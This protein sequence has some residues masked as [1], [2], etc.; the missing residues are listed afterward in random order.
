VIGLGDGML[1]RAD[2]GFLDEPPPTS[3]GRRLWWLSTPPASR[4][5]YPC[6]LVDKALLH[7]RP[8]RRPCAQGLVPHTDQSRPAGSLGAEHGEPVHHL[9]GHSAHGRRQL[10]AVM[11]GTCRVCELVGRR[12]AGDVGPLITGFEV[13]NWF[14]VFRLKGLPA[15]LGRLCGTRPCAPPSPRPW[16]KRF[17]D[18][19]WIR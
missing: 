3:C 2:A 19:A 15:G 9:E 10:A 6:R 7:N 16:Q 18:K 8:W 1:I 13:V 5:P 4:S 12:I 14:A 17:V 11:F